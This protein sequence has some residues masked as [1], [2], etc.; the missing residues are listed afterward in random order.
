VAVVLECSGAV[1]PQLAAVDLPQE[2]VTTVV[3]APVAVLLQEALEFVG[4]LL[5]GPAFIESLGPLEPVAGGE[6]V[7]ERPAVAPFGQRRARVPGEELAAAPGCL[8]PKDRGRPNPG[9]E[10]LALLPVAAIREAV[11]PP[12]HERL[13]RQGERCLESDPAKRLTVAVGPL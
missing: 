3:V 8:F 1:V 9:S 2:E 4:G 10:H 5:V 13:L 6:P 11:Q 12:L 7:E